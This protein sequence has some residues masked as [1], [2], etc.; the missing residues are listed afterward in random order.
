MAVEWGCG[1]V[2]VVPGTG[3][4]DPC[5]THRQAEVVHRVDAALKEVAAAWFEMQREWDPEP[6]RET[7]LEFTCLDEAIGVAACDLAR[8][9]RMLEA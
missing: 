5:P 7:L 3:E 1:C 4:I 6:P 8:A 9:L 2:V